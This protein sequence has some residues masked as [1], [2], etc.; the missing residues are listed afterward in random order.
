MVIRR[1]KSLSTL[2]S[3]VL[4]CGVLVGCSTTS[5]VKTLNPTI[6]SDVSETQVMEE[7]T[8]TPTQSSANP[9]I[10]VEPTKSVPVATTTAVPTPTETGPSYSQLPPATAWQTWPE[11]P[12]L[13][14]KAK[15]IFRSGI[16]NGNNPKAFSVFGDCQSLPDDFWGRYDDPEYQLTLEEQAYQTSIDWF[17][18][19]FDRESV[20]VEKGTTAAA[21]L[22]VGWLD[23]KEHD[24]LYGETPLAC[25]VRIHNPSIVVISLGTHWELRNEVYLRKIIDELL[26][27]NVLP[28]ISTKADHR[29]GEAWVN[30]QMVSIAQ[31]YELPVWN[32]WAAVQPLDNHGMIEGDP[33]YMNEAGLEMQRISALRMLDSLISQLELEE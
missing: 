5:T 24:C 15:D 7:V 3:F 6:D 17:A 22:W 2:F 4:L 10:T 25:E 18:G 28:V 11:L 26:A 30:E 31:E 8:A 16:T 20:T 1:V 19:S 33:M 21:I 12:V 32:F 13:S 23:G 14:E 29:E 9:T 27:L